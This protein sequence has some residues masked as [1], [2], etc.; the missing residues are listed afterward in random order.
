MA[1][2][3]AVRPAVQYEP[4]NDSPSTVHPDLRACE[5]RATSASCYSVRLPETAAPHADGKRAQNAQFLELLEGAVLL[6]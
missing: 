6:A 4:A 1:A 5:G 3:R 2:G